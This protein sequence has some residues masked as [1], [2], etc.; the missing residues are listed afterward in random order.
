MKE[1]DKYSKKELELM[2]IAMREQLNRIETQTSKTNGRVTKL[3]QWQAYVLGATAV[4]IVLVLPVAFQILK[5]Y[6]G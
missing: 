2:F 4:L 3:E 1:A 5:T 6:I